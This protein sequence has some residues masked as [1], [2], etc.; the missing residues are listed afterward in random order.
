MI[1]QMMLICGQTEG[2]AVELSTAQSDMLNSYIADDFVEI[3]LEGQV[4]QLCL[5]CR[6]EES[7]VELSSSLKLLKSPELFNNFDALGSGGLSIGDVRL[8]M[9]GLI[10]KHI[11]ALGIDQVALREGIAQAKKDVLR[12]PNHRLRFG[13]LP[14]ADR[15]GQRRQSEVRSGIN[16]RVTSVSPLQNILSLQSGLF[17]LVYAGFH[18]GDD[19]GEFSSNEMQ[20]VSELHRPF[21]I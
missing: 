16:P 3:G 5:V 4:Q 2:K 19:E 18:L 8:A 17:P 13:K 12:L 20:A 10:S 11:E 21:H 14:A 7:C 1:V 15:A 6:G 9:L